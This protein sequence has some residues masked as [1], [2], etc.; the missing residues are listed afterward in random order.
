MKL[1]F[2][3]GEGTWDKVLLNAG[4]ACRLKSYAE[5][6][7]K[8]NTRIR[9][10]DIMLDSGAYSVDTGKSNIN[11][12]TYTLWLEIYLSDYPQIKHYVVLDNIKSYQITRDNQEY[13]EA[14]G[15]HPMPVFHYGEPEEVLSKICS[16]HE[17]VG[18]GG[19]ASNHLNTEK[20]RKWWE[21]VAETYKE[22]KFHLFAVGNMLPFVKYKPYSVDTTTWL[23]VRFGN[24]FCYKN[25]L[26]SS[27]CIPQNHDNDSNTTGNRVFFTWEEL[28]NNNVR[29]LLDFAKFEW[30]P[31][32][33]QL[34][35]TQLRF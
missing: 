29:A 1:Y 8:A 9:F 13:M 25:G 33:Q 15:L 5:I 19:V 30:T 20:L 14:H 32:A 7:D 28:F 26:P 24:L 27:M 10:P 34:D 6:A 31:K 21:F 22:N 18:L 12:R 4:V 35:S 23:S 3:G 2:S 11:I 16:I 17:Y